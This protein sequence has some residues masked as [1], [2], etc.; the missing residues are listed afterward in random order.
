L[1]NKGEAATAIFKAHEKGT[2]TELN[3]DGKGRFYETSPDGSLEID[4]CAE[5]IIVFIWR[6]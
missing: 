5:D 2:L 1:I 6:R 3:P 4:I